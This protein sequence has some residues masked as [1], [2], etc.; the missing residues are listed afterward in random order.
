MNQKTP[1]ECFAALYEAANIL[2]TPFHIKF[3]F[4]HYGMNICQCSILIANKYFTIRGDNK[5]ET[6]FLATKEAIIYCVKTFSVF[7]ESRKVLEESL[8]AAELVCAEVEI[9]SLI[10]QKTNYAA[11]S[12]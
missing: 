7:E 3:S 4:K 2:Q 1:E 5:D 12:I 10:P 9:D 6:L 8:K 11:A